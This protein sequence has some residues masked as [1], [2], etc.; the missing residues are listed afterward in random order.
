MSGIPLF[1]TLSSWGQLEMTI[2]CGIDYLKNGIGIEVSY[3][4]INPQIY[5]LFFNSELFLPRQ[6]YS[7]YKLL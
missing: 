2:N 4:K 3:K 7:E 1:L 5:H 6:S